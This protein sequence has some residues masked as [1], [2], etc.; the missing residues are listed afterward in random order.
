MTDTKTEKE[1]N[2]YALYTKPRH[3]FKAATQLGSIGLEFFLPT[4][5]TLKQWSDR[6]KKIVEPLLHSYIFLLGDEKERL[7]ALEQNAIV[8]TVSFNGVPAIVPKWQI[9]SLQK[10]LVENSNLFVSN[11]L[12]TG[13]RVKIINGPFNGAEGII[14]NLSNNER[15]LS[16]N[17]DLLKRSVTVHLPLESVIKAVNQ[18]IPDD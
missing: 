4:I 7:M 12:V 8:K 10:V 11:T 3:E 17:L 9:E 6:K 15:T 5:T 1:R 16:V 18:D 2:W 14:K 13:T